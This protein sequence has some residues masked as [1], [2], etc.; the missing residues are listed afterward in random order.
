MKYVPS[1]VNKIQNAKH[2]LSRACFAE[3]WKTL[4]M[5]ETQKKEVFSGSCCCKAIKMCIQH[6]FLPF[7]LSSIYFFHLFAI[8]DCHHVA[9]RFSIN[10][11]L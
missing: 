3:F 5:Y 2:S 6:N 9:Q 10:D 4:K 11:R 7:H 8:I 1:N